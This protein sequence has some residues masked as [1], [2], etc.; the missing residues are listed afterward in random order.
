MLSLKRLKLEMIKIKLQNRNTKLIEEKFLGIECLVENF[1]AL[2]FFINR[3]MSF[4]LSRSPQ[5]GRPKIWPKCV[6]WKRSTVSVFSSTHCRAKSKGRSHKSR[7]SCIH[8]K[9]SF[10]FSKMSI[11][12]SDQ[13]HTFSVQQSYLH[14]HTLCWGLML[15]LLT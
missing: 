12:R 10:Y 9:S 1:L 15:Q 11:L 5:V 7:Q 2:F 13:M 3:Q 6:G 4:S 14:A 8:W